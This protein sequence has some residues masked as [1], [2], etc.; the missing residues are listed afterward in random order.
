MATNRQ[1]ETRI[2]A[3]ETCVAMLVETSGSVD[4]SAIE[5][6][7]TALEQTTC[8]QQSVLDDMGAR[9]TVLDGDH[10]PTP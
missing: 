2:A 7:L 6:R 10:V 8:P 5:S 1:L 3:L 4:L 9:L